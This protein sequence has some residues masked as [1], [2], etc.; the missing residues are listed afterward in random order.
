VNVDL[1]FLVKGGEFVRR[2][3]TTTSQDLIRQRL[4]DQTRGW[5]GTYSGHKSISRFGHDVEMIV[6]NV[7]KDKESCKSRRPKY[8]HDR[9]WTPKPWPGSFFV[10]VVVST[11]PK[12]ITM[13][14]P[15]AISFLFSCLTF[16][17]IL[18]TF[19][20]AHLIEIPAG[21]KECFFEDLHVHDKVSV[22]LFT[23]SFCLTP[24]KI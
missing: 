14:R 21:K 17:L 23:K 5:D 13:P 20:L 10:C 8:C 11:S 16:V 4:R 1:L 24:L 18:P 22:A 19:V 6:F 15:Y 7:N 3:R 2:S 12:V 9:K